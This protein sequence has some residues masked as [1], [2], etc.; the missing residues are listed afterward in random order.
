LVQRA[1]LVVWAGWVNVESD[2]PL[3]ITDPT[4]ACS[5]LDLAGTM[6][7]EA[8]PEPPPGVLCSEWAVARANASGSV[9]VA[10]CRQSR[11]ETWS[12]YERA[13]ATPIANGADSAGDRKW[14]GQSWA[15]W[16]IVAGAVVAVTGVVLWQTGAFDTRE[17]PPEFVFTGPEAGALRF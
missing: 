11:C 7:S 6:A 9:E 3:R 14:L 4:S 13:S 1:G 5:A 16:G 10:Q 12:R 17:R 15:T 2:A 8:R